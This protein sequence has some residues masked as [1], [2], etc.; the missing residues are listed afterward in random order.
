MGMHAK[1]PLPVEAH[2]LAS[3]MFVADV[4]AGHGVTPFLQAAH[5]AGCPTSDGVGMV[6]AGIKLMSDFLLGQQ[7]AGRAANR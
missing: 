3:S 1:D 2:L 5:K 7:S 6:E 4:I